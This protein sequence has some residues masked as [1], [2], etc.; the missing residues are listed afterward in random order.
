M[1]RLTRH[2]AAARLFLAYITSREYQ[3]LKGSWPVRTDVPSPDGLKSLSSYS[4]TNPMEFIEWMRGRKHLHDLR[5]LLKDVFGPVKGMPPG[6]DLAV[7]QTRE[8]V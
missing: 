2:K 7:C 4:N 5:E 3:I 6:T 1:F 8:P